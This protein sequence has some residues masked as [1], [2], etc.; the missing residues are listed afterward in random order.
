[1]GWGRA[2]LLNAIFGAEDQK[3]KLAHSI[4]DPLLGLERI[5]VLLTKRLCIRPV[6][7]RSIT[8]GVLK[9]TLNGG[10]FERE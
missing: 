8:S 4:K 9:E 1:M 10:R 6:H 3:K 5:L 2:T 7:R